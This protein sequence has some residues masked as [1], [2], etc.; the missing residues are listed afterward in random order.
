MFDE[1][2]MQEL[3]Y[4]VY[5][6]KDPLERL[7]FY[8]GKGINNR[9]FAHLNCAIENE[10]K[11]EKLDKIREIIQ[12]EN[13]NIV[14][15]IIIRHGLTEKEA[16]LIEASMIDFLEY[17]NTGLTNIQGG[18]HSIEKGLM[19]C[20]EII[21]YYNAEPLKTMGNDCIIININRNYKRGI[22]DKNIYNATK[23]CW[24]INK[25]RLVDKNGNNLI[26]YVLSEYRGLIVEV[27][28][29]YKW[30]EAERGFGPTAKK[31]GKT[32]MG[33]CFEGKVAS[34]DIRKM[35]INKSITK[36]KGEAN[37]IKYK[38]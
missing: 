6:L 26:K 36:K 7:P 27:F 12:R 31:H 17:L 8:I 5:F 32:K 30:Y 9:V 2:T 14:E 16:Y 4:Y 24:S 25:N 11:S 1:K 28:E 3:K 33:M 22:D 18:H 19:T 20:D 23:A 13:D 10:E 35:Y 34:E 37:I 38:I 15:H 29:V 21:R